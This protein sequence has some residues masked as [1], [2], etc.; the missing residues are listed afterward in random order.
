VENQ[1]YRPV[2]TSI[3][4]E[5]AIK[6]MLETLDPHSAFLNKDNF[7]KNADD[8]WNSGVETV[9]FIKDV[10][11][12]VNPDHNPKSVLDYGCGVGRIMKGWDSKMV[13]GCDISQPHLDICQVNCPGLKLHKIEPGDCPY[14]YDLI[15]SIITLQH[16]RP[17]L[18]KKCIESICKALNKDGLAFLHIPYFIEKINRSDDLMEMNYI[19][20]TEFMEVIKPYCDLIHTT[21]KWDL[22]GGGIKNV[23]Y[24][25]KR[26]TK[27]SESDLQIHLQ[28]L[29][30]Q[31]TITVKIACTDA[32]AVKI[33]FWNDCIVKERNEN[34]LTFFKRTPEMPKR[35]WQDEFVKSL[36]TITTAVEDLPALDP[37]GNTITDISGY[38]MD[39][40]KFDNRRR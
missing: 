38:L 25:I 2:D 5:G 18:M 27:V 37:E 39:V 15:Y 30:N 34:V 16:N 1:Y 40:T 35:P 3:L 22:C 13:E 36:P 10:L 20:K 4:I 33:G 23:C 12:I 19:S 24:V 21:E 28:N 6:G 26:C 8:F 17:E 32:E 14:G 29:A 31:G 11:A 7:E 9:N